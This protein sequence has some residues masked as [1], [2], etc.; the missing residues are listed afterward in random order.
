MATGTQAR[1]ATRGLIRHPKR[2][3]ELGI[4][5]IE[6]GFVIYEAD[7]DRAHYLNHSAVAVLELCDGRRSV[8]QIA[9]CIRK[10]YDLGKVPRRDVEG[11]L[12]K[13]GGEGLVTD[14]PGRGPAKR[15]A[16]RFAQR[17][18]A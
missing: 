13:L 8:L 6:D 4:N 12:A 17:R 14:I 15:G 18:N 5:R 3:A 10:L 2:L 9:E 1:R 16:R 11:V 7:R